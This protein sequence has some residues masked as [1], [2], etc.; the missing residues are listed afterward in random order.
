MKLT[1]PEWL[2]MNALWYK[3]P[4][5]AR[6]VVERLPSTVNWAYTTVKTM[7]DRLVEKKVVGKSKRGNIGLYEP[8]VSRRQARRTA[9]RIMLDQAF[10]GA[11]GPMIH[12]LVEDES[13]S[14]EER[15]EL[16]KILSGKSRNKGE[17]K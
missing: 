2:I 10:D 1:E 14:A 16:I 12:F 17:Q 11:F 6:D 7:L 15:K 8:L 13:L 3:H 9:M 4:V 5:K